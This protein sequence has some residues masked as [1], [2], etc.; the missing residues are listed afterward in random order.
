MVIND[1]HKSG[2]YNV[3]SR[4]PTHSR[5]LHDHG[6]ER[7]LPPR[8]NR[9]NLLPTQRLRVVRENEPRALPVIRGQQCQHD[10]LGTALAVCPL[11]PLR[12]ICR[13]LSLHPRLGVR[14]RQDL[15]GDGVVDVK[16]HHESKIGR[17]LR[18]L[19]L[20]VL[21]K[22][23]DVPVHLFGRVGNGVLDLEVINGD[24]HA[25]GVDVFVRS[26]SRVAAVDGPPRDFF[27]QGGQ[28]RVSQG[29][30]LHARVLRFGEKR[31]D[32]PSDVSVCDYL[33]RLGERRV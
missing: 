27:G 9:R 16:A 28:K 12:I 15:N 5:V 2:H 13:R 31:Q 21:F 20:L 26:L 24:N 4:V 22:G 14:V 1:S 10:V 25:W 6:P 23:D 30:Q 7:L 18:S 19:E 33:F 11:G 3:C 8:I 29:R 32:L 17:R